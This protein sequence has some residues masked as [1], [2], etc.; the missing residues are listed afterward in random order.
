MQ[1]QS[2]LVILV[3]LECL[4]SKA[5]ACGFDCTLQKHIDAIQSRDFQ[6]FETTITQGDELTFILPNGKLFRSTQE[7]K[8][9]LKEWFAQE[10][11]TFSPEIVSQVEG[12]DMASALLLV[13]YREKD[14]NGKPYQLKHYLSLV[15][16]KEGKSWRLIHDQNT[17]AY[18]SKED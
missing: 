15:F 5:S 4:L 1:K 11:W 13:D 17:Q 3:I 2:T 12:L 7:Y 14:R 18:S 16:K 8:A 10:G 9:L 6:R